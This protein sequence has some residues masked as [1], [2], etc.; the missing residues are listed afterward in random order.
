MGGRCQ[1]CKWWERHG[2]G[3]DRGF[4]SR[5]DT[6]EVGRGDTG[7]L[8]WLRDSFRDALFETHETFGCVQHEPRDAAEAE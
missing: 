1:A 6:D 8:A 4:C 2:P 3:E 7:A 5:F